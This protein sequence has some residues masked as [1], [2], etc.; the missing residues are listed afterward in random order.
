M[1]PI[2][3]GE[4]AAVTERIVNSNGSDSPFSFTFGLIF[5]FLPQLPE[6]LLQH[7]RTFL[8]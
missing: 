1:I 6:E 5:A 7:L 8:P 4:S 2:I 3:E